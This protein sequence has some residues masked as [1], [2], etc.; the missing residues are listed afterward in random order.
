MPKSRTTGRGPLKRVREIC[1]SPPETTEK[2]AWMAPT[3]RVGKKMFAMFVNNHHGDGRVALWLDAPPGVQ[4]MLVAAD[5]ARF[6]V[7]PYQGPFGWIG[8][9][10]DLDPDWD[11]IRVLVEEAYRTSAPKSVLARLAEPVPPEEPAKKIRRSKTR[12]R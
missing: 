5:P 8:V 4:E 10:V 1:L 6:F 3:F 11:E 2:E 9:R 7:P 12:R